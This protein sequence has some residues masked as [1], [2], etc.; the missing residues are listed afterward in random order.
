MPKPEIEQKIRVDSL[1][2]MHGRFSSGG[3]F[4]LDVEEGVTLTRIQV[5]GKCS[6]SRCVAMQPLRKRPI[7]AR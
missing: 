3:H 1:E 7:L 2:K 6:R 4:A 5:A